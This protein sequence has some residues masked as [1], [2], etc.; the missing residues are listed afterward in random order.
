MQILTLPQIVWQRL[1][2]HLGGKPS[3]HYRLA[4]SS[5]DAHSC[6]GRAS[7]APMLLLSFADYFGLTAA[8]LRALI[9]TSELPEVTA[10]PRLGLLRSGVACS[11]SPLDTS[12][13][14]MR[15]QTRTA[16]HEVAY[17]I[18]RIRSSSVFVR[19]MTKWMR[20]S[21]MSTQTRTVIAAWF[22]CFPEEYAQS[23]G[24]GS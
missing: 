7:P 2:L 17:S 3:L 21:S 8:A 10:T 14:G 6:W 18:P 16:H 20:K 24:S 13:E 9:L 4:V 5:V 12:L 1:L 15:Q 23:H 11:Q 19:E 22:T